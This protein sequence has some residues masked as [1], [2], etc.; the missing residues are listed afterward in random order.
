MRFSR[1]LGLFVISVSAIAV[2]CASPSGG[3]GGFT[4]GTAVGDAGTTSGGASSGGASSGGASSSGASSGGASIALDNLIA[5]YVEA[6]CARMDKCGTDLAGLSFS[7]TAVCKEQMLLLLGDEVNDEV[8]K[9]KAGLSTYDA[10]QAAACIALLGTAACQ[11]GQLFPEDET[12][13]TC[14]QTFVG[15][16]A[17]GAACTEGDN[18]KGGFCLSK[19]QDPCN[20]TCFANK[21]DGEDCKEATLCVEGTSCNFDGDVCTAGLKCNESTGKCGKPTKAA[22]GED[23]KTKK[24]A[25]GLWCTSAKGTCAAR[26]KAGEVCDVKT[27]SCAAGLTC[28]NDASDPKNTVA[29]CA[30]PL[31]VGATCSVGASLNGNGGNRPCKAGLICTPA[32]GV[33]PYT[34]KSPSEYLIG[35]CLTVTGA[36]KTCTGSRQCKGVDQWC[37]PDAAGSGTCVATPKSGEACVAAWTPCAIGAQCVTKEEAQSPID[38]V[39]QADANKGETCGDKIDCGNKLS[40]G[41]DGV[42]HAAPTAGQ[43]C[44]EVKG[45]EMWCAKGLKC[46]AGKCSEACAK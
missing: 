35:A 42:C 14:T 22:S 13:A 8:L 39:C 43:V 25:A 16:R 30:K 11:A 33:T 6:I 36:G 29:V 7:S 12:K 38:G 15:A 31:S 19:D 4:G 20:A 23:C 45:G 44:V 18:C 37:K 1:K 9:V 41:K 34:S 10:K 27:A 5:V 46:T 40:C 3:G 17:V 2:G 26:F 21:Q 28:L 24:C 32:V